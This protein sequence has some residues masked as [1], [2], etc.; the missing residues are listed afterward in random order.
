MTKYV[1][2]R[3]LGYLFSVL[4]PVLATLE[5][6]PIWAREG[7][8]ATLSGL[9]LLLLLVAAIPLRRGLRA[10]LSRLARSP[11]AYGIWAVIWLAAAWFGR[12]AAAIAEIA[13]IGTLSSLVGALF[14][15]LAG[16]RD[17]A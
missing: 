5:R 10:A 6:F 15:R 1:A 7:G 16:R 17:D 8:R 3:S 4:P 11:S 12:I 2:L 9:A 14:F 13:L